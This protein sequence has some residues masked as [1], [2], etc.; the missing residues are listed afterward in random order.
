MPPSL[1]P[2]QLTIEQGIAALLHRFD[3]IIGLLIEGSLQRGEDTTAEEKSIRLA[4]IGM[5]P[6]DI[7]RFTSRHENNVSRDLSKLSK[8]LIPTKQAES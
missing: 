7:A 2:T 3:L 4:R 8:K 1:E 6:I 5:R